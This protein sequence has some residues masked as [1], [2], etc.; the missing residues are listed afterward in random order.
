MTDRPDRHLGHKA[1]H[2]PA[3]DDVRRLLSGLKD[4]GPMPPDLVRR[5][6]ASLA[7]EQARRDREAHLGTIHSL[8]T[9]R[10]RGSMVR[11]LP[12]V[13]VAATVVVL[14]GAAVMGVLTRG[15]GAGGEDSVA[16]TEMLTATQMAQPGDA[17]RE[18]AGDTAD[19]EGAWTGEAAGEVTSELDSG[20]EDASDTGASQDAGAAAPAA[21]GV[22]ALTA[23]GSLVTSTTLRDLVV[24]LRHRA[25]LPEDGAARQA[26][27]AS[28][29]S[30]PT[31]AA[32]CLSGLLPDP[33]DELIERV[34]VV[35]AVE[36]NGALNALIILTDAPASVSDPQDPA[37]AYLVPLD[38]HP[39][40]ARLL[41]EPV[42]VA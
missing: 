33:V 1:E 5:I 23:S 3:S 26:L 17:E 22:P 42:R 39:D 2:D 15:M 4:P 34:D 28:T 7:A 16:S 13:A 35:D 29:V 11:R 41:H 19:D 12:A 14:A 30:T 24:E 18:S 6:S 37:T 27:D 9:A 8:A 31:D 32:A 10:E 25:P 36:F 20:R 38:C 40:S 21:A